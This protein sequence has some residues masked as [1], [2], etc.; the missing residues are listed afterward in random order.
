MDRIWTVF[1]NILGHK[2][3]LNAAKSYVNY[4]RRNG[5]QKEPS[6][7]RQGQKQ[8]EKSIRSCEK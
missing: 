2:Y 5:V 3:H 1:K 4:T 8:M 7:Y 6:L